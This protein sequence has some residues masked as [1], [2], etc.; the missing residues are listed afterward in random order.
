V[1]WNN[2]NNTNIRKNE[3][4][5]FFSALSISK[6]ACL[7]SCDQIITEI[8]ISRNELIDC[9]LFLTDLLQFDFVFIKPCDTLDNIVDKVI[10]DFEDEEIILVNTV[11]E[12]NNTIY[13]KL[14]VL[15]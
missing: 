14:I 6:I 5:L 3:L 10:R 7:K 12:E 13:V 2:N 1:L 8:H 15:L 9:V 4:I 11:I